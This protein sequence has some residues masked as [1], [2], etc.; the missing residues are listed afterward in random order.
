MTGRQRLLWLSRAVLLVLIVLA[1]LLIL[2]YGSEWLSEIAQLNWEPDP[3]LVALSALLLFISLWLTPFA[4]IWISRKLG[5]TSSSSELRGI[6]FAS[7]LG[8]YVPGKIWLFVGRAGYLKS[9]G[10]STLNSALAPVYE[11]MHTAAAVGVIT[12]SAA[13]LFPEFLNSDILRITA[14]VAGICM[15]VLPLLHPI[16][17]YVYRL[18]EKRSGN[19]VGSGRTNRITFLPLSLSMKMISLFSAVFII[20]GLSLFILL[21][22]LGISSKGI[23]ACIT[24][25]PLSWLAGYIVFLVPGGI[26]VREAVIVSMIAGPSETGPVLAAVLGQRLLL[27]AIEVILAVISAKSISFL[28][29]EGKG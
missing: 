13:L 18:R 20:R 5:S 23:L 6:W 3:I 26:G 7:H 15:L 25:T 29:K 19:A 11:L 17:K 16:Q 24:A 28:R 12:I 10:V 9:N 22:A 21:A 27:A 4:W 1:I 8:R 14:V 2:K